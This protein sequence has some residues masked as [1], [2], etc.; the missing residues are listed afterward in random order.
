ML[1]YDGSWVAW[2][3]GAGDEDAYIQQRAS[4]PRNAAFL[5]FWYRRRP[6]PACATDHARIVINSGTVVRSLS[7]CNAAGGDWQRG[8]V[9]LSPYAGQS[10]LLQF[11]VETGPGS[12]SSLFLDEIEFVG[13]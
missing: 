12:P 4:V 2:L 1:P 3:G 5:S 8:T 6:S 10:I 9:N 7:L 11:R 13:N